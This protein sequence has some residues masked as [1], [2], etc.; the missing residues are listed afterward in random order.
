VINVGE[1]VVRMVNFF[2]SAAFLT[3]FDDL[4]QPLGAHEVVIGAPPPAAPMVAAVVTRFYDEV[5]NGGRTEGLDQIVAQDATLYFGPEL[6]G[7]GPEGFKATLA[8]TRAAFPD[9]RW[10]LDELL[11]GPDGAAARFTFHGTHGGDFHGLARTGSRVSVGG[12]E[13][14]RI[15]GGKIVENHVQLDTGALLAQ[16]G[17]RPTP[18]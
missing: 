16:L 14:Y 8:A 6:R 10:M 2:S 3:V 17:A 4:Y 11:L 9:A 12:I 15:A 13:T 18:S 7:T 1:E 5:L